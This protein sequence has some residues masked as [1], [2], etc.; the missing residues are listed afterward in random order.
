MPSAE[1][2]EPNHTV[3]GAIELG[4]LIFHVR[5]YRFGSAKATESLLNERNYTDAITLNVGRDS[6]ASQILEHT[7][8]A[9]PPLFL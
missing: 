2:L 6:R 1:V 9:C 8:H 3:R 7:K 5:N 4:W